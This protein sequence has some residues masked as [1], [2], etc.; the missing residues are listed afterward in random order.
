MFAIQ[1]RNPA[2]DR[3]AELIAERFPKG[4]MISHA[5]MHQIANDA[6]VEPSN[7]AND[8]VSRLQRRLRKMGIVLHNSY[9]QGWTVLEDQD[10]RPKR[11]RYRRKRML[12]QI[13]LWSRELEAI[14]PSAVSAEENARIAAEQN[15][16]AAL[17][18]MVRPRHRPMD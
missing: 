18:A 5:D 4:S 9:A 10:I 14:D 15:K 2:Y 17:K 1:E 8:H 11:S 16:N 7:D 3:A 12:G 6:G 13:K